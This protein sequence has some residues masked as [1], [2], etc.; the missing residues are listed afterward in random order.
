MGGFLEELRPQERLVQVLSERKDAVVLD[1][2]GVG[3]VAE[4]GRDVGCQFRAPGKGVG[5]DLHRLAQG[6]SDLV[7]QR[8]NGLVD[9]GEHAAV[10]L[11][12]VYHGVDVRPVEVHGRVHPGLDRGGAAAFLHRTGEI[13]DADVLRREILVFHRRGSHCHQACAVYP[14]RDVAS[15]APR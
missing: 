15:R 7:E 4:P 2:V 6:E 13:N 9:Q 1:D 12:G 14:H 3:V 10:G 11:V 8:G 5:D